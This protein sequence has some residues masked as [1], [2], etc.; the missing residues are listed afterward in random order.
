MQLISCYYAFRAVQ[1]DDFT[2][3]LWNI[4]EAVRTEGKSQVKTAFDKAT[5]HVLPIG[6]LFSTNYFLMY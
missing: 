5:K 3:R 6:T 4:Y 2:R 1:V